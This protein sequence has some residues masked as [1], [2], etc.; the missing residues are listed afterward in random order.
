MLEQIQIAV[1]LILAGLASVIAWR[2]MSKRGSGV[3]TGLLL[4]VITM[5]TGT[6][7]LVL[8]YR[9]ATAT[10]QQL[11]AQIIGFAPTYADE[12]AR[13]G[14]TQV[15]LDT[16][17][18]DPVYLD[19]IKTQLRWLRTNP[20]VADIYSFT[21]VDGKCRL[22][23]DSETDYNRNG[24][25][26]GVREGRT[27][28]GESFGEAEYE[29]YTAMEGKPIFTDESYT[30]R[31][32][33]WVSAYAPMFGEDGKVHSILGV[34]FPAEK[35]QSAIAA[36]QRVDL[37]IVLFSHLLIVSFVAGMRVRGDALDRA[38][39]INHDLV[40]AKKRAEEACRA[41]SEF[42]ANMSHE[43]R[44]PMNAILGFTEAMLEQETGQETRNSLLIV[45]RN[46]AHL[47]ALINDILDLSRVES[48]RQTFRPVRFDLL[49]LLDDVDQLLRSGIEEKGLDFYIDWP[50]DAPSFVVTDPDR[51]R[52]ILINLIGNAAK[53]THEGHIAIRVR[54]QGP[55]LTEEGQDGF[56]L[57]SVEDTGIGMSDTQLDR[58]FN[59]FEQ[60]DNSTTRTYGGTGLGLAICTRLA[61]HL[62]GNVFAQS[63]P[64]KGSVFHLR[65]PTL[66][67]YE[68]AETV[69]PSVLPRSCASLVV[70]EVA[71]LVGLRV[72]YAEDGLDNQRLLSHHLTRAG[73]SVV[74]VGN[75]R[76]AVDLIAED[77]EGFDLVFMDLQMPEMDGYQATLLLRKRG[78]TLPI[79]ALT[80]HA[81]QTDR[82]KCLHAG[83]D[84]YTTKPVTR[85]R[86]IEL[87]VRWGR[88]TGARHAA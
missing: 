81:M 62:G 22:I 34:D 49:D 51:I 66:R 73:A 7:G 72:L 13:K 82:E 53:F 71:P 79:V 55:V 68:A 80:A 23:V 83:C 40:E 6:T 60:A 39:T 15:S 69:A 54:F 8:A 43:I 28:I 47:L 18:D 3:V 56:I 59:P 9:S 63:S 5:T 17:P 84:D 67:A 50:E 44:T 30:D 32:G 75:G 26:E 19:L 78:C 48:G 74:L 58:V 41:K 65:I 10:R 64:G 86:L 85:N 2:V 20:T 42:L 36:S 61:E 57:I 1:F 77:S 46:A 33:T 16:P 38:R 12:F 52:Q 25:F 45:R 27:T 24:V 70:D 37:G 76:E 88:R 31:W 4:F 35:W 21:V 11:R 87:C 14:G 29:E